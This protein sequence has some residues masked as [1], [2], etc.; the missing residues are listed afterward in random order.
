[1]NRPTDSSSA[2]PPP[3]AL[4]RRVWRAPRDH[5]TAV[6]APP[7]KTL[8]ELIP[9]NAAL[10]DAAAE[11]DVQGMPLRELRRRARAEALE[12]ASE[13]TSR[14]LGLS[15][16]CATNTGPLIVGGHQPEL[17]HPGVWTKNHAV[18]RLAQRIGGVPL[19]LIVDQDTINDA[20]LRLPT[21][22]DGHWK[23]R[24]LAFDA[25]H[26]RE[27]WEEALVHDRAL[28]ASF[29]ERV[30]AALQR[31]NLEPLAT[32]VWPQAV[33]AIMRPSQPDPADKS[34]TGRIQQHCRLV[35]ALT[36]V[37]AATE[38]AWGAGTLELPMSRWLTQP[39]ALWWIAHLLAQHQQIRDQYNAVLR[40]YRHMNRVRSRAHPVADLV[41][42]DGWTEAPFWIWQAGSLRRDR[43]FVQQRGADLILRDSRHEIASLPLTQSRS[44]ADAVAVLGTLAPH[45]W[46]LRTRALTTTWLARM[47]LADV[48]IHGLGGAKYDEMTDALIGR[49]WGCRPPWFATVT[50]TIHLPFDHVVDET[51][52]GV[53]ARRH[54]LWDAEHN[55][56]R[57]WP[58]PWPPDVAALVAEKQRLLGEATDAPA[59]S[60]RRQQRLA[61]A[62]RDHQ[63]REIRAMLLSQSAPRRTELVRDLQA[64]EQRLADS[65]ILRR[66]EYSWI[67]FPERELRAAIDALLPHT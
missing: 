40:E 18:A 41:E 60:S 52:A 39:A 50:A 67:L 42:R 34:K 32:T 27:P 24:P 3:G 37:R 6:I 11:V 47:A 65:R 35:D 22:E 48:F 53:G 4:V 44:A 2:P 59:T 9:L 28:F 31:F 57:H 49:I 63:L 54:A 8:P 45:G 17:F 21:Q 26:S 7:W 51:I 5:R 30:S 19:Q 23:L 15:L 55:P 61:N 14:A 64:A 58:Q 16:P 20:S 66:R 10:F 12:T 29:G 36:M 46:R 25:A 38:R 33:A 13:Y 62:R 56:E 1:M 43:L